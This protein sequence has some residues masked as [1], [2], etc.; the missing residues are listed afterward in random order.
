M[1]RKDKTTVTLPTSVAETLKAERERVTQACIN[2]QRDWPNGTH[3][4]SG[5]IPLHVVLSELLAFKADHTA[6]SRRSHGKVAYEA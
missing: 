5:E 3:E 4:F 2:G 1:S 6:R